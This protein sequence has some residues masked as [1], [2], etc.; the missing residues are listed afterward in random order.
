MGFCAWFVDGALPPANNII[1]PD[2]QPN[3]VAVLVEMSSAHGRGLIRGIA[4]YV[5]QHT[6]WSL[7]LE[8]TGPLR[9]VPLWLKA[10]EGEGIIARIETPEI[11]RAVV[12]K[13]TPVVNV[14][15]R[16]S[17]S[18]IPRVDMD[19]R[20]TADLAV[21]HFRQRGYRNFAFCGNPRFEW[22]VWRQ[23]LFAKRLTAE[24]IPPPAP[25]KTPL[26]VRPIL[27]ARAVA[28]YAGLLVAPV[29][30]RM[31]RDVTTIPHN[32]C[33]PRKRRRV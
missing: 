17:P 23:E 18:G 15:G 25:P 9:A 22:S 3:R 7:H 2:S 33:R 32:G 19:D 1:V 8:E 5:H 24:R 6:D 10:W 21:E 28:E 11:A 29:N 14:S 30:L 31:E 13:R 16:T 20:V 27:A 4:E 26:A 12:A